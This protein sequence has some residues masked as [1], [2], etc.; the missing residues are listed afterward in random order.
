MGLIWIP[1]NFLSFAIEI[2]LFTGACNKR[3]RTMIVLIQICWRLARLMN[4]VQMCV[5]RKSVPAMG[6]FSVGV[7]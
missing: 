1:T 2:Y 3:R 4:F 5:F 7:G 6:L